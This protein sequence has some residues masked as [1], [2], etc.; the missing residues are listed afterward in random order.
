MK[1]CKNKKL[2]ILTSIMI[3][4]PMVVGFIFWKQLPDEM[5][6]HFGIN[7][8]PNG[9]SSKGFAVIGL[10]LVLLVIHF[11]SVF[12]TIV[13]PKFAENS[14]KIYSIIFWICP[15]VSVIVMVMVYG[16]SLG[17]ELNI[18]RICCVL[19]AILFI[20]VGNY[21]PKCRQNHVVGIRIPWTL[22]DRDN[23]NYT[24]RIAGYIWI[25]CGLVLLICS[26]LMIEWLIV[27]V[28]SV[29]VL[30][31]VAISYTYYIKHKE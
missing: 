17:F 5:A 22:S 15:V 12:A 8:E 31:P 23:W 13:D 4:L 19:T 10:P 1:N 9:W 7:G 16:Y 26:L 29:A 14:K 6:T 2:L 30:V 21:L 11:L 24:H 27:A 28:L 3:L 20:I 18:S 25:V